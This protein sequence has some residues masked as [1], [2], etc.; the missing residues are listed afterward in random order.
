[1]LAA[2]GRLLAAHGYAGTTIAAVAREAGVAPETVYAAFG[3]KRTLV[4]ELVQ[5]AVRGGDSAPASGQAGA[6]AVAAATDRHEQVR[7]FAADVVER[8]ERVG[9][10]LQALATAAE[11][12][13]AELLRSVDRDRLD[14][15]RRFVGVLERG[16]PLRDRRR[17]GDRDGLGAREPRAAQ[18]AHGQAGL[19]A[20]ALPR[21][22]GRHAGGGAAA[23]VRMRPTRSDAA[24]PDA[25]AAH[26]ATSRSAP[27]AA[28]LAVCAARVR[29]TGPAPLG[30]S[31]RRRCAGGSRHRSASRWRRARGPRPGAC[32]AAGPCSRAA[33]ASRRRSRGPTRCA[34]ASG[35]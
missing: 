7:L 17:G 21:L 25:A 10:V 23:L 27:G 8:L 20:R 12:E 1:M 32:R 31:T 28:P 34:A 26:L 5:T 24:R 2:A 15:L 6:R 18:H 3:N 33:D 11:P 29:K 4:G 22:A 35:G 13:L 19:V 9:P 16:G 30:R 14:G